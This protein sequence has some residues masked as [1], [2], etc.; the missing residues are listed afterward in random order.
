MTDLPTRRPCVSSDVGPFTISVGFVDDR[1]VEFFVTARG[2]SGTDL[3]NW[4]YEFGVTASKIMQH[5]PG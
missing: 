2:K 4:L 3:D 5:E 1:P